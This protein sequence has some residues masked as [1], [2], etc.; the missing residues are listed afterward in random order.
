[1]K[2]NKGYKE[3]SRASIVNT[4]KKELES[5]KTLMS[6]N[7]FSKASAELSRYMERYP[8][9]M[10]GVFLYGK[11]QLKFDDIESAKAAFKTVVRK[12]GSNK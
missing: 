4:R 9:D 3:Q 8:D 2:N 10:F 11:L 7:S 6:M 5:I 12:N 1:M